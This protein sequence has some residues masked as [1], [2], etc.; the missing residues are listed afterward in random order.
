MTQVTVIG[1]GAW[2]TALAL[3]LARR[4]H[5]VGLWGRDGELMER[6]A[7]TRRND[8]YLPGVE[9]P[10]A[11]MT[12]RDFDEAVAAGEQLLLAVPTAALRAVCERLKDAVGKKH[13]GLVCAIKGIEVQ[14]GCL[15]HEVVEQ[16]F[17]GGLPLCVLAGPSFAEEVAAGKPTAVTVA[18]RGGQA[19]RD[20]AAP[21]HGGHLRAYTTDDVVGVEIGGALK[22]VIAIAVGM[23]DG[24][25][26]GENAK[27]ALITRGLGE[28]LRLALALGARAETVT[29]LAGLGDIV[30]SCGSDLSRN[31]RFGLLL[32]QGL[33]RDEALGKTGGVVE[34]LPTTGIALQ[35]ARRHG[36][37]MPIC[38]QVERVLQ[39]ETTMQ[40]AVDELLRRPAKT[41]TGNAA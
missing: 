24:L 21:F 18:S 38:E 6:I 37:E 11:M 9:L 1:A 15:V 12:H 8:T 14:S 41:E 4:G 5:A 33:G 25:G 39:G 31:R 30:L 29:G 23:S 16:A 7:A 35:L 27:A 22:N 17:G 2:G 26:F 13:S 3:H 19:A 40:N 20:G 28:I 34:G 36:V 32:A 10:P